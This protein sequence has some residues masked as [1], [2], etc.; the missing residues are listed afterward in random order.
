MKRGEKQIGD[1][2]L[3]LFTP[4]RR[5]WARSY[6]ETRFLLL[7]PMRGPRSFRPTQAAGDIVDGKVYADSGVIGPE[8]REAIEALQL[9]DDTCDSIQPRA[10]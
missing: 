3:M 7:G 9:A 5:R 4:K 8:Q 2:V 10:F 1:C 6:R